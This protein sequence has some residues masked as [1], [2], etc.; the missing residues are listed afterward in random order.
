MSCTAHMLQNIHRIISRGLGGMCCRWDTAMHGPLQRASRHRDGEQ[1]E[2][3]GS[4]SPGCPLGPVP[5][6]EVE[7]GDAFGEKSPRKGPHKGTLGFN[8]LQNRA[9]AHQSGISYMRKTFLHDMVW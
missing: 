3:A 7:G 4:V 1:W 9:G 6:A 8:P 5:A 2:R